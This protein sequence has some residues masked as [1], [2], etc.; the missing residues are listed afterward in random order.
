MERLSE[1]THLERIGP[2]GWLQ[3]IYPFQLSE[4]YD[5]DEVARVLRTGFEATCKRL[6]LMGWEAAPDTDAKRE[7]ER[8]HGRMP[9]SSLFSCPESSAHPVVECKLKLYFRGRRL[10]VEADTIWRHRTGDRKGPPC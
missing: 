4:N 1:L 8:A 9:E 10:Q 5:I 7:F 2:K 3:Y 6:P